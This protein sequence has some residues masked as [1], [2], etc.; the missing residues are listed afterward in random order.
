[1]EKLNLLF[2]K[3]RTLT[4]WQRIF[5]W[6]NIK[7]L[8]DEAFLEFKD[9]EKDK[10]VIENKV[11]VLE[12][13]L[14]ELDSE[15]KSKNDKISKYEATEEERTRAYEKNI[16]LQYQIKESLEKD[17]QRLS[18]ERVKEKQDRFELMKKTWATHEA[19]VRQYIKKICLQYTIDYID[20]VPF[21]GKPDNTIKVCD[22]F[23][24]FDAKSPSNDDLN[25]F[26]NY[27]NDQTK[28][29]KKYA[30]QEN[31]KKEIFLVIP[32]NTVQV[33]PK[34][35]Y[36]MSDYNVYIIT[37]D[38][39][40]PIIL[41]LK[42][43]EEYEFAQQLRPED[44]DNICRVIGKFTHA[45]KRKILIDQFFID[46]NLDVL[47]K[48][49]SGIPKDMLKQVSEIENAETINPPTDRRGKQLITQDLEDKQN[50]IDAEINATEMKNLGSSSDNG[51]KIN[52]I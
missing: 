31:V 22:E 46:Y 16:A 43:I 41:T 35:S 25:N 21:T 32:T 49:K 24:I 20:K 9:S 18:D 19:D 23:I 52:D 14:K 34:F 26:A 38:S 40:E 8:I 3:L 12:S 4:F 6:R 13:K 7:I 29:V 5:F 33:I 51:R 45:T 47:K 11:I 39:I 44:R 50:V 17:R 42:R 2:I 37:K 10:S 36:N 1:M 30:N 15:L 48:C 27:I 28:N